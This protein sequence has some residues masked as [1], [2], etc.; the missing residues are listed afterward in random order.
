MERPGEAVRYFCLIE[1]WHHIARRSAL[2]MTT[3]SGGSLTHLYWIPMSE[4]GHVHDS[5]GSSDDRK[6][7]LT[8]NVRNAASAKRIAECRCNLLTE[9]VG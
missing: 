6:Q 7:G 3:C 2:M 5:K 8:R 9:V 4:K 1:A